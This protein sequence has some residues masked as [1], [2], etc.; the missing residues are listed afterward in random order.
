[1]LYKRN[2]E[3]QLDIEL[4]KNPTSEYRGTPFWAWNT[5]LDKEELLWQIE[6]LKSMG[7]GGFH[8]HSRSGM[9]TK[10]LS[11]EFMDL[12]KA[13]NEKA[14]REKMLAW[15]YDEDRW[16]S[17]AAGGYVTKNPKHRRK[18]LLFTIKPK[19]DAVSKEEGIVSGK[20]YFLAAY[21]I[22]LN[23]DGTLKS[24]EIIDFEAKARGTKWYA[25]VCTMGPSGWYNG[26][27]YVDTLSKEAIDEF[28]KIT[29]ESYE[30]AVGKDFGESVPAIFTDE[31][32]FCHKESL[33]FADSKNDISL[34]YTTNFAEDFK[35][36][37][38]ID[39]ISKLPELLWDLPDGKPSLVR[40]YYHD[41]VCQ[42]F[43]ESFS[44]NCGKW[45]DEHGICLTGHLMEED[46]LLSQ[47]NALGEAMRSYRK[48]GLPGIDVLC[49]GEL[50]ATAKQCQSAV[51]QYAREGML[52]ELY[53]VTGWDFDFRGHK[54][55]GDWQ[56]ALGV[57][58]RVPHLSW[59]SMKGSAKRDYPASI[60][61]QSSWYKKYPLIENHFAR[62]N[63]ALTRGK[64]DVKVAVIHPIE[65]YWLHYGPRE[66]TA[67]K[68]NVL[69][70][71]FDRVTNY[72]LFSTIDFDYVSESLLPEQYRKTAE[73][74][75]LGVGAMT[76]EA[77]VVPGLETM[78]SSTLEILEKFKAGGGKVIFMGDC[79]KYVDAVE[80]DRVKT[81]F[82]SSVKIPFSSLALTD[83]LDEQ[84]D[85]YIRDSS[86]ALTS[87]LLYCMRIDGDSKWL[88][89]AHGRKPVASAHNTRNEME[90][91]ALKITV[92]GEFVPTVYDTMTGTTYTP[93]Y[94]V[95]NNTT[96][97]SYTVYAYD[98]LLLKL[99]KLGENDS[100]SYTA[101]SVSGK[102]P[103]K[104]V[105]FKDSVEY[106]L[107]EQNVL[108]LDMPEYS[109]DGVNYKPRE[110]MLRIDKNL[111]YALH[112][113]MADGRDVQPWLIEKET[114]THFPYLKFEF[115]SEVT[116]P[117]RLAYEEASQ[118]WFNGKEVDIKP[119]GGYFTDKSVRTMPMPEIVKGK[120]TLII[121]AP[122]GK[123]VSLENYFLLGEFGVRTEG[124]V[125]VVTKKPEKIAFGSVTDKG[126][127]FY[128]AEI[129]Y[130]MEFE[131]E[132]EARVNIRCDMY[133]GA[134]VGVKLDSEEIGNVIFPPYR[135]NSGKI[136]KGKHV[137]ELTLYGS[138]QNCFGA[139]H[140]CSNA[141]WIGPN[142]WYT[143]GSD[144]AY[145]YQLKD[146]GILK[147]P[148][149]EI[150][151]A[152]N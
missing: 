118:V 123:R 124:C 77:V 133:K 92:K 146:M 58:I 76:Y 91:T 79:P 5:E 13:C 41:F 117:C 8:M 6:Q 38:G 89:L 72:L 143:S 56:A 12:V 57:T 50:F 93:T 110:E 60:S 20:P 86:G 27:T 43:T 11:D 46:N 121:K 114:I 71:N 111:R 128:G 139:L 78:R 102:S 44:D 18:N 21:D 148:V 33:P 115:D 53:G 113:P 104:T 136:G 7:F 108:V 54:Y 22:V 147:S 94:E 112:Y 122:I 34:P 137:L 82:D 109:D 59:V 88:F 75:K 9:A 84:R 101:A 65:S 105:D 37:Y 74:N 135:V 31:P 63:T 24:A 70:E 138:R 145:E 26:Q 140:N 95:K 32:Q 131:T 149:I 28:I 125:S 116:V 83:A 35:E 126:L 52:S 47:T 55:Q 150:F 30:K 80:S 68:R 64:P 129:T 106:S 15:L 127:P 66:N 97:I 40:Y 152:E 141:K 36:K 85:V 96:I 107:N 132:N 73:S 23:T 100:T 49:D 62:L 90:P 42:K 87:N 61:Y 144:W 10:Y 51:H 99:D 25:Y 81:L 67:E 45:C 16:P 151:P 120:N 69:Q 134:L 4:F 29:Y 119:D 98:S 48:F 103:V 17:G 39:L 142:Y 1:M 3:K 2:K 130:K 14:K 19:D